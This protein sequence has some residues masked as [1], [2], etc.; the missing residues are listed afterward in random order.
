MGAAFRGAA[1][2]DAFYIF[3][4]A[5]N[6]SVMTTKDDLS[7][8]SVTEIR[9]FARSRG[10]SLRG[11]TTK[12]KLIAIIIKHEAKPKC[13]RSVKG[14]SGIPFSFE[15]LRPA[16]ELGRAR[17]EAHRSAY[18]LLGKLM[19]LQLR[20]ATAESLT[21][22][23]MFSTLVDIPF[24]G[25]HKY[26]GFAVYETEAKRLFLG[27]KVENVYSHKCA[28]EMAK[29]ALLNSNASLAIA[30][31]GNAMPMQHSAFSTRQ[32]G[33]VYIGIAG[34]TAENVITVKTHVFNMCSDNDNTTINE[35]CKEWM[36]RPDMER[37]ISC[38]V[39]PGTETCAITDGYNDIYFTSVVA[40]F[41]RYMTVHK[42]YQ[43]AYDFCVTHGKSLTNPYAN[44]T[45][46]PKN[47]P[48]ENNVSNNIVLRERKTISIEFVDAYS[49]EEEGNLGLLPKGGAAN[50]KRLRPRIKTR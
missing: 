21:A 26:G 13:G 47:L 3:F 12:S 19:E 2:P 18:K 40:E 1:R 37:K 31:T 14:G 46:D 28:F 7:K 48:K 8:M 23:L 24:G 49:M 41:V 10:I 32:L 6:K 45:Y 27:V 9:D 25:W 38:L 4:C 43:F 17:L 36:T 5:T 30:V 39:T 16:D 35:M 50:Q 22:G 33:E 29:G 34:Y 15:K 11:E 20:V 44:I 42:A